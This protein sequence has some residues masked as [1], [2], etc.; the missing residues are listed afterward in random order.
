MVIAALF[1]ACRIINMINDGK[2]AASQAD[3][4]ALRQLMDTFMIEIL[5]ILPDTASAHESGANGA[6]AVKPFEDAVDLLLEI[7]AGAKKN[8]D[9]TTSDL[10]RNRLSEIGFDI[11]DTKDGWEWSLKR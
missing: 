1:E 4:D 3:I 11:K 10:I 2:A 5:G 8:K 7:R 6:S 9:W